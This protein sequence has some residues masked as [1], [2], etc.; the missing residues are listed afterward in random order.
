MGKIGH[1]R[2]SQGS[3]TLELSIE[4]HMLGGD[5]FTFATCEGLFKPLIDLEDPVYAGDMTA[6]IWPKDHSGCGREN[7]YAN[8]SGILV[9]RHFPGLIAIG[10]CASVIAEIIDEVD[11]RTA[12]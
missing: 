1:A 3:L 8:R 12:Y 9:G 11:L 4:I 10:D 5:C 6:R 2:I 7:C